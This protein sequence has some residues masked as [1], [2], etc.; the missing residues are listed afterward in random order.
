MTLPGMTT[1]KVLKVKSPTGGELDVMGDDEYRRYTESYAAYTAQVSLD[2]RSDM[3]DLERILFMEL[4]V[5]RWST[6]MISG[7][8]YDG[9]DI[10][11]PAELRRWVSDFTKN[12]QAIKESLKLDRKGRSSDAGATFDERWR[13]LA[14]HAKEFGVMREQQLDVALEIMFSIFAAIGTYDRSDEEERKKIGFPDESALLDFIREQRAPFE[15]VDLYF[16]EHSH[17]LWV[18][19]P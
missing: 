11:N 16:R 9:A 13:R 1:V 6:W 12:I 19:Q 3:E 14:E 18:R 2:E 8:Q 5:Y 15:A 17:K 10:Q 7:K 4:M